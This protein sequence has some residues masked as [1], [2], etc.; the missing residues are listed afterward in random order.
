[1]SRQIKRTVICF[2]LVLTAWIGRPASAQIYHPEV[3][4]KDSLVRLLFQYGREVYYRGLDPIEAASVFQK[5]LVLDCHHDGAQDFIAKIQK[6]YPK[7]VITVTGCSE[8]E[9]KALAAKISDINIEVPPAT[10]HPL[11]EYSPLDRKD[12][13]YVEEIQDET[14]S[15][16]KMKFDNRS[17]PV[18]AY[19][20]PLTD[21]VSPELS[22]GESEPIQP[23]SI[24]MIHEDQEPTFEVL[25][26]VEPPTGYLPGLSRDCEEIKALNNK[27][28][29][30][31][32]ALKAQLQFKESI[33]SDYQ[34]QITALRDGDSTSY[35]AIVKE[36]KE[37][38][39]IQQDNIDYLQD[40]LSHSKAVMMADTFEANPAY[41]AMHREIASSNLKVHEKEMDL[42]AKNREAQMLQRQLGELQEQ[43][44]LVK[45]ILGEKNDTIK[46]LQ[47]EIETI[48]AEND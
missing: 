48:K 28:E 35:A 6:R 31:I 24:I 41:E 25:S 40:E 19:S 16:P 17:T 43:L 22:Q 33:I 34:R 4:F 21:F 5:I 45:K 44:R 10:V 20:K 18:F 27:L 15:A 13:L 7:M 30:E 3:T 9:A 2:I 12:S 29:K 39:R 11:K 47:E 8:A 26:V 36:Q 1:M 42:E 38:I 37:L 23:S 46:V 32:G 14:V